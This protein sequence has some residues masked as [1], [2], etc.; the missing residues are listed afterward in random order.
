MDGQK[1]EWAQMLTGKFLDTSQKRVEIKWREFP[2]KVTTPLEGEELWRF[3]PVTKGAC[4]GVS[5]CIVS[6][7]SLSLDGDGQDNSAVN[8]P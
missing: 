1:D 5:G 4:E 8:G 7:N 6:D 3:C 2:G